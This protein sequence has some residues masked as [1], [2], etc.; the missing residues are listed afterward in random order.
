MSKG[1]LTS[2]IGR[3][4]NFSPPQDVR[5]NGGVDGQ[6]EIVDEVWADP[7]V[8]KEPPHGQPCDPH[9]WGDYSFCSQLIKWNDGSPPSIRFAYYRRRCGEDSWKFASQ[10]TVNADPGTI[11]A[12]CE[13]TLA[14]KSWFKPEPARRDADLFVE[15]TAPPT[16]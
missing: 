5:Q 3:A 13:R 2:H 16:T 12:L 15:G 4:V 9:C 7:D 14:A 1:P 8:N 6:G 11:K 10:T